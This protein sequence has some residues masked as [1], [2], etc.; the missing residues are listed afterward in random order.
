M[1]L[2]QIKPPKPVFYFVNCVKWV[3]FLLFGYIIN[4]VYFK[5]FR[6]A[7]RYTAYLHR[8]AQPQSF[9]RDILF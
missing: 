1:Q 6:A 9:P 2:W 5:G 7:G 3:A 4:D 8:T